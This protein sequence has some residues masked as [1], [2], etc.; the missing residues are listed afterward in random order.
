MTQGIFLDSKG[1]F[2]QYY[3]VD[4]PQYYRLDICT[5]GTRYH[6]DPQGVEFSIFR[7]KKELIYGDRKVYDEYK[8]L[9][10]LAADTPGQE[11]TETRWTEGAFFMIKKKENVRKGVS[12]VCTMKNGMVVEY[13]AHIGERFIHYTVDNTAP[14]RMD[15]LNLL[16]Y[17][18]N[19]ISVDS[20]MED[21]DTPYYP[22]EV[23]IKRYDLQHLLDSDFVV[24]DTLEVARARFEEWK[25]APDKFKGFDTET[26]GLDVW[27]YGKDRM[28]GIILSI[29]DRSATYYPFRMKEVKNLPMEFFKELIEECIRQQDR[30][31]AHNKQFDRQV[32]L[33]EGYDLKIYWDTLRVSWMIDPDQ[34]H[35]H[36]LKDLESQ[37]D[38]RKYLE[39]SEIFISKKDINFE[40]LPKELV[41][42]Y[43]CPD[44]PG[45]V[46][47]L[48]WLIPQVPEDMWPIITIEMA[49][50]DLKA[51]Q[52]FY[53]MRV[54]VA[55]YKKNYE[56]CNYVLDLLLTTFR[57]M[58]HEDG[59]LNSTEVLSTLLY[60]KLG[61]KV[62]MRTKTGRRSTSG[63]A[64]DKLAG[65]RADK[66]HNITEN[67]TDLDG[68][69]IIKAS[70]LANS[71]YPALVILSK[72]R[73][74]M[75]RKTAFY[76]RFERTVTCGRISFWINQNGASSGRQSSPMH[77][78][79]PEL[80][81][82]ILSDSE[83]KDLWG[84]D[85]SQVE[86]RMI[87]FLAGET[88]LIN[89]CKDPNNDI[90]R[91]SASLITGKPMWQITQKERSDYKRV[92]FGVVYL[93]SQFGL[94]G[95]IY[96][97]GYTKEQADS[98]G[99][100]IQAFYKRFKRI[101]LYLKKNAIRVQ[102]KGSMHTWFRRVK[103]FNKIFNP[104][105]TKR[106]RA[107]IIRQANNMPV[108][109]TAADLMK[110]AEVNMFRYIYNKGWNKL[111]DDGFPM[112]RAMLSIHDEVLISADKS[113]P[114]EE[115]IEMIKECM[116]IDIDGAPPFFVQPACMDNWGGHSDDSLAIPIT[117]RDELIENYKK[118][119]ESAFKR[120]F[121]HLE[122]D[123]DVKS[124]LNEDTVS[125]ADKV[126][127]YKD[128][129]V[130]TKRG[131]NYTEKLEGAA[132]TEAVKK[133]IISGFTEYTDDN[134][135]ELLKKYREGVLMNYM[136]D[137]VATYGDD[138]KQVAPHVQH[139][140]LTHQLID[141]YHKDMAGL[142]LSHEEQ[143]EYSTKE[144]IEMLRG[145]IHE[146]EAVSNVEMRRTDEEALLSQVENLYQFD[147]DG[148]LLYEEDV[149][150]DADGSD[151]T[152]ETADYV[153]YSTE[154]KIY[155]AWEL[156]DR[157]VL[158]VNDLLYED[159]DKVIQYVWKYRKD[160][161]F[162][163]V[164]LLMQNKL[165]P[166]QFNVEEIDLGEVSDYIMSFV[167][168]HET[169]DTDASSYRGYMYSG[170]NNICNSS[171]SNRAT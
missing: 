18:E 116:Q 125:L 106:E 82:V 30:L 144:Y 170:S 141:M 102:E 161:G 142:G 68:K 81:D 50:S 72:Y 133:Y 150:Q 8:E 41:Q 143:I 22:F 80:K 145:K 52:E 40:V 7:K 3:L 59:N 151:E 113:I 91:V 140:S 118:T 132:L 29:D 122:L 26:T 96:G 158:D 94:A 169:E 87:A 55:R 166:A 165:V 135:R 137:L 14:L 38:Q 104:D 99:E 92:N 101:D 42:I 11:T 69:V 162:Y 51:D 65:L 121:Y 136:Q 63:K 62:L 100:K 17:K 157:L 67:I 21:L 76:A 39:L 58:T 117:Y 134:Y 28:V 13:E 153:L 60:D 124:A 105:I 159:I 32:I 103:Y 16:D 10:E 36:A 119:E 115:I 19:V 97:P 1:Y 98:C 34:T 27:K 155:K 112:V 79:P 89:M 88:D 25:N 126:E 149:E 146:F 109:G 57:K 154:G 47:V 43:A 95:Q 12:A 168:K 4:A 46:K 83:Q 70:T 78:L 6:T 127:K 147:K 31:V 33:K 66:P 123:K 45:A 108:Q 164:V 107:S 85:Y 44:S 163:K 54:D 35:S 86:L 128:K 75:K 49:L 84:P 90:H 148:K 15:P 20:G 171:V 93:I 114:M 129:F 9:I 139:P 2:H 156:V 138:Y 152:D 77:Q 111:S 61:C 56:N 5:R 23:L 48:K 24:A 131:G 64:I 37:I 160:D 74:Y 73:E 71:K 120:S 53:G 110:I 130:I 167:K